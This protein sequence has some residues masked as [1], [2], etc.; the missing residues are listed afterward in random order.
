MPQEE[1]AELFG[2]AAHPRAAA[3][4]HRFRAEF[5]P[6]G[7]YDASARVGFV[8]H[9]NQ[10]APG[11]GYD[12][13]EWSGARRVGDVS[14]P[15]AGLRLAYS[16][17]NWLALS[18]ANQN[19]DIEEAQINVARGLAGAWIGRRDIGF[20]IGDG[21]GLVT[22]RVTV[23]GAGVFL[24]R[25]LHV[26]LVG[27]T[28]FE[29]HASQID[30]VLNINGT[31]RNIEPW[32]WMA[33]GS[34]EPLANLRI[35][36][37]RGMMFGGEGNLPVTFARIADNVMGIYTRNEESSFANQIISVDF[38]YRLPASPITAYLDWGSDDGAG[39]WWDVPGVLAGVQLM[40]IDSMFDATLGVEHV[41]FSGTCCSNSIW[42]RNVW[43]RGSWTN[44][45]EPLGHP[46]GGHGREWRVFANGAF[47]A[48]K[49]LAAVA[50]YQRRRRDENIFT[51][52]W[53]GKSAGVRAEADVSASRRIWLILKA[54]AEWGA[55]D[56]ST[57]RASVFL[58]GRF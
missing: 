11:V 58:R 7:I 46:L 18:I 35:G 43:F 55:D 50:V 44:G 41:Q 51:P 48:D 38:R 10:F 36:I 54:E 39:G 15:R 52:A 28:R 2:Q 33:R 6:S 37:N 4:L 22:D 30:N 3:Y 34:I 5:A 9:T 25:P 13:A 45:D 16:V 42:Y 19:A 21:G 23:K 20:G 29:M 47:A 27:P 32:F 12:S 57:N 1:I 24:A 17:T 49:L 31:E 56:W 26:P 53:S 14:E 40:H 8:N